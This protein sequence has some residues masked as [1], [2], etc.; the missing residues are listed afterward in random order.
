MVANLEYYKVFYQ[1]VKCGSVT[2]AAEVLSLSQ[3][4]VSQSIK[5]LEKML[6]VI[7]LNR[8]PRGIVPTA[9][10]RLLFSYVEKGYEQFEIGERQLASLCNLERG[11]IKIGASDMT[12]RFFLLPYLEKFHEKYPNV[13]VSVTNGPTPATM[14]LLRDGKIDFGVISGP[15][16]AEEGMEM[17]PVRQIEDIFVA[18]YKYENYCSKAQPLCVLEELPLILLEENSS[19]R[20]NVP[21]FLESRD[22]HVTPEFELAT[23]DM[24]VQFALRNLGVGCVVRDF[25]KEGLENGSLKEIKFDAAFPKR[26]LLVV[27]DERKLTSVAAGRLLEMFRKERM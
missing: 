21:R 10:G 25:A 26:E 17:L 23:S 2:K 20:K 3:P 22:V 1:V 16:P 9:E 11:E 7:L 15:Q 13:R 18:G 27:T 24:I 5:Q 6:G 14:E 12:L 8:T 19:T 4:A